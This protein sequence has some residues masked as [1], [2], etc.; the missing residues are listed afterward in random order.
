MRQQLHLRRPAQVERRF[1][2]AFIL[3]YYMLQLFSLG[4]KGWFL[5]LPAVAA[6]QKYRSEYAQAVRPVAARPVAARPLAQATRPRALTG[7]K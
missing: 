4:K 2:A 5:L 6:C 7:R 3:F 1:S